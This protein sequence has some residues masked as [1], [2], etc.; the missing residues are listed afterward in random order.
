MTCAAIFTSKDQIN[1]AESVEGC[2]ES[3]QH[4]NQPEDLVGWVRMS[5][6]RQQDAVLG[7]EATGQREPGQANCPG[8][9]N[10]EELDRPATGEPAHLENV[11][12]VTS[13]MNHAAGSH[14]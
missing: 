9:K 7:E 10:P 3:G 8:Q 12:F 14:K 13:Q 5:K 4:T 6:E 1:Q 11:V 2:Q